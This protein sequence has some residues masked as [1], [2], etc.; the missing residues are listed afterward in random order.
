MV[1]SQVYYTVCIQKKFKIAVV[2]YKTIEFLKTG[3]LEDLAL[4]THANYFSDSFKNQTDN[5][6]INDLGQSEKVIIT[7][8]K[9][10]FL[11]SKFSK[12]VAKRR[13]NELNRE[14]LT[15]ETEFEKNIFKTRIGRLSGNI[16]STECVLG[17]S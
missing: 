12:I 13:I 4:L 17:V 2:R 10:T 7:K 11:I 8:E 5:F 1:G 16:Y 3:I 6:T 15:S 9:S 14:L